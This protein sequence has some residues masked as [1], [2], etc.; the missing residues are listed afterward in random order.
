MSNG[1]YA[2]IGV[3]LGGLVTLVVQGGLAWWQAKRSDEAERR[4]DDAEWLVAARLLSEELLRLIW[5]LNAMISAGVIGEGLAAA[6][7]RRWFDTTLWEQYRAV[8]ARHLPNDE[9]GDKFWRALAGI[10]SLGP[11]LRHLGEI[12]P[13]GTPLPPGLTTSLVLAF[14]D[15]ARAYETLTGVEPEIRPGFADPTTTGAQSGAH[16]D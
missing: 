15:A 16:E 2:L 5:D 10:N 12:T 8:A 3:V 14:E 6:G 4:A 13:A 1:V 11:T 9:T 7:S